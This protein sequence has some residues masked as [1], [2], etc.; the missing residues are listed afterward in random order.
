MKF[1]KEERLKSDKT[2]SLL[3]KKGRS[4]S[5]YPLRLV[6]LEVESQDNQ[7]FP[8]QFS[9]TV[10]KKNFKHAVMRNLLRRRVRES[11]RLNKESLYNTIE[12]SDILRGKH[13]AFMVMYV[14]KEELPYAEI[15]RGIKKMM[16]KFEKEAIWK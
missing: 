8:I 16:Y 11:Y 10:P 13:F 12:K 1:L 4:F 2:I 7:P 6:Y 3:F 5:C 15:E 14:A 9:L